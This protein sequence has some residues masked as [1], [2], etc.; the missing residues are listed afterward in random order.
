MGGRL[1]RLASLSPAVVRLAAVVLLS[2]A[3]LD[4]AFGALLALPAIG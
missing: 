2:Q 4:A 1:A 3:T